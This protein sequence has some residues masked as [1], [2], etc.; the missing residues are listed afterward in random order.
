M[1][2]WGCI[3]QLF[4]CT[5]R[6][7]WPV[8]Q[9]LTLFHISEHVARFRGSSQ[10]GLSSRAPCACIPVHPVHLLG[11]L[12]SSALEIYPLPIPG[13]LIGS[14]QACTHHVPAHLHLQHPCKLGYITLPRVPAS[15][16]QSRIDTDILED[17]KTVYTPWV[18]THPS[19]RTQL[20]SC[21]TSVITR[22][23]TY[24]LGYQTR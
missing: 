24:P 18:V 11:L 20:K 13:N 17:I 15:K 16:C 10:D 14:T 3:L 22:P 19:T 5:T 21:L 12:L 8:V 2:S 4:V 6:H 23:Q 7:E 1:S 9:I